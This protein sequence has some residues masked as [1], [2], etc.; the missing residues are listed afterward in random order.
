MS[1]SKRQGASWVLLLQ[2]VVHHV[3]PLTLL[4][5]VFFLDGGFCLFLFQ[6]RLLM[7]VITRMMMEETKLKLRGSRD[8]TKDGTVRSVSRRQ[9]FSHL[10]Q[11]H[12]PKKESLFAPSSCGNGNYTVF[13]CTSTLHDLLFSQHSQGGSQEAEISENSPWLTAF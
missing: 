8:S 4:A 5:S 9:S 3:W 1:F 11:A 6:G 2:D 13:Q 12:N 7:C 10:L